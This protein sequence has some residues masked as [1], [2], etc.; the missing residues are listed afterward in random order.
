MKIIILLLLLWSATLG[1]VEYRVIEGAGG[2]PLQIAEAGDS[3]TPGVLFIHGATMSSSSW[4]QQLESPMLQENYHL[5]AFDL[6]GHG[7]SAKPWDAQS[8][9][10]SRIW[11]DD[12]AA[13]I[14]ATRLDRPVIV[15]WSLHAQSW[16][17][18]NWPTTAIV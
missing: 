6:R 1:A 2:L 18:L 16:R 9:S 12:V 5:V 10:D 4:L 15:A 13:V 17:L 3:S 11:A 7:N 8:Y 14:E